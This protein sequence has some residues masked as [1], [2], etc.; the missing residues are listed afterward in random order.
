MPNIKVYMDKRGW[1]YKVMPGI[2][3]ESFK[4]RYQ[5]YGST[6]WKCCPALEWRTN[7]AAAQADLD[8]YAAAKKMKVVAEEW[9]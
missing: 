1:L 7:I 2:G 9:E 4:A 6:G 3:G 5:K 8:K